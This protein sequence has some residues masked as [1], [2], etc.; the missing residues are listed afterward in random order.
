MVSNVDRSGK[1]KK[2]SRSQIKVFNPQPEEGCRVSASGVFNVASLCGL[3]MSECSEG[4][5][6]SGGMSGFHGP[7]LLVVP[8]RLHWEFPEPIWFRWCGQHVCAFYLHLTLKGK[9]TCPP[10]RSGRTT[11]IFGS[12][13]SGQVSFKTSIR[14]ILVWTHVFVLC[15]IFSFFFFFFIVF[16]FHCCTTGSASETV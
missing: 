9:K 14:S 15:C 12:C 2:G 11:K 8:L 6:V 10:F 16:C 1:T 5:R 4:Q 3:L 7:E 13:S